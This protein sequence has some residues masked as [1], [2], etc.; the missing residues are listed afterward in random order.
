[1]MTLRNVV[2]AIVALLFAVA[3]FAALQEGGL[4]GIVVML[5]LLL[6]GLLFERQRYAVAQT[7]GGQWQR[8]GETFF[9]DESGEQLDVWFNPATGQRDY[10]KVS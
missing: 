8:T 9:D 10:R 7:P 5:G 6:V 1:M 2:I 3:L 4:I